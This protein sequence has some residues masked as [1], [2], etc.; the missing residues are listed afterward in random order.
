VSLTSVSQ[1][2]PGALGAGKGGVFKAFGTDPQIEMTPSQPLMCGTPGY[3]A[4]SRSCSVRPNDL[5]VQDDAD[6]QPWDT[7]AASAAVGSAPAATGALP[8]L[9]LT[10]DTPST[11]VKGN[12][13]VCKYADYVGF[14]DL[15]PPEGPTALRSMKVGARLEAPDGA[16]IA[17]AIVHF[18][19]GRSSGLVEEAGLWSSLWRVEATTGPDG[20][21]RAEIPTRGIGCFGN[22]RAWAIGATYD[23]DAHIRPRHA[24]QPLAVDAGPPPTSTSAPAQENV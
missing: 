10:P 15:F 8:T 24:I 6:H 18:H 1:A 22:A 9:S 5:S 4:W 23:G 12:D 11:L 19:L 17:G 13:D 14:E 16:P 7:G 2:W 21:A 20:I 3:G